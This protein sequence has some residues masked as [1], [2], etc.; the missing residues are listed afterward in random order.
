MHCHRLQSIPFR[1]MSQKTACRFAVQTLAVCQAERLP[2]PFVYLRLAAFVWQE[3]RVPAQPD[4]CRRCFFHWD[5]EGIC[6]DSHPQKRHSRG[7]RSHPRQ[8]EP[9]PDSLPDPPAKMPFPHRSE[10]L[11]AAVSAGQGRSVRLRKSG[12]VCRQISACSAAAHFHISGGNCGN[13]QKQRR[14]GR[15]PTA[16]RSQ[17]V[18]AVWKIPSEMRLG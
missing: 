1:Q 4:R 2:V 17:N 12:S 8:A 7:S 9:L 13:V 11:P 16:P 14:S 10:G 18:P 3:H 6:P 15:N 5:V